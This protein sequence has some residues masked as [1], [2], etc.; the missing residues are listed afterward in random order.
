MTTATNEKKVLVDFVPHY[1]DK[2]LM[3]DVKG[4]K[5]V[6]SS[7]VAK[8]VGEEYKEDTLSS[9]SAYVDPKHVS[10]MKK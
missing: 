5:V 9:F 4:S 3:I 1:E 7:E 2:Y 6:S 10:N 8:M